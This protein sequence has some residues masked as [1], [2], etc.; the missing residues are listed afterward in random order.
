MSEDNSVTVDERARRIMLVGDITQDS[1]GKVIAALLGMNDDPG[2]SKGRARRLIPIE[3]WI[4]SYGGQALAAWAIVDVMHHVGADIVAVGAGSISSAATL[5]LL[6][7][8]RR[9]VLPHAEVMIHGAERSL[10]PDAGR[11]DEAYYKRFDAEYRTDQ[12][13]LGRMNQEMVH[14]LVERAGWPRQRAE[15]AIHG[16]GD[17][18][19]FGGKSIVAAGLADAV[20]GKQE[21]NN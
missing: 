11:A 3:L 1:A 5:P 16:G 6:F 8:D 13:A 9:L 21:E 20:V 15:L 7:A 19:F 4:T 17:H 18:R 10:T 14:A 12:Y 2:K